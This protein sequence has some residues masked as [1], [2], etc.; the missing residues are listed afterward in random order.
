MLVSAAAV[1]TSVSCWG[2][3]LSLISTESRAM[4][5]PVEAV[6]RVPARTI[7]SLCWPA[8]RFSFTKTD[9]W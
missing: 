8:P 4:S 1:R 9:A 5:L 6:L 2:A 7:R 3:T